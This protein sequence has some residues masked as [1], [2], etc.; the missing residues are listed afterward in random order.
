MIIRS[1]ITGSLLPV[2]D[3][4]SIFDERA[5]GLVAS[6]VSSYSGDIRRS[7]QVAKRALEIT[8]EEYQSTYGG[9]FSKP[10]ITVNYQHVIRAFNELYNSK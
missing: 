2:K 6:K 9:D 7:L 1:R 8:R 10:L 5:V 4:K 3:L